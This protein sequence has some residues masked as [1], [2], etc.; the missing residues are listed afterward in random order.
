M[1][2]AGGATGPILVQPRGRQ[3]TGGSGPG[4]FGSLGLEWGELGGQG[5]PGGGGIWARLATLG[6]TPC[7]DRRLQPHKPIGSHCLLQADSITLC[8]L[9]SSSEGDGPLCTSV[10]AEKQTRSDHAQVVSTHPCLDDHKT[11]LLPGVR[12]F[13]KDNSMGT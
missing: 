5:G 2:S 9:L 10:L 8:D 6:G 7:V 4:I 1:P 11:W 3:G 12:V 13:W